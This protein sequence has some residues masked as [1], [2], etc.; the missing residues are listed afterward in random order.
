MITTRNDRFLSGALVFM[1]VLVMQGC[2]TLAPG[3]GHLD[4]VV[5]NGANKPSPSSTDI[6]IVRPGGVANANVGMA[7]RKADTISTSPNTRAL[8]TLLESYEV[9]LDTGTVIIIENPTIFVK[10]GQ[11]F[12]R[13][14]LGKPD[15]MTVHTNH[16]TILDKG[17]SFFVRVDND[18]RAQVIVVDGAVTVSPRN[19]ASWPE[20]VYRA[21]EAATLIGTNEPVSTRVPAS[22]IEAE[23]TWVRRVDAL[24]RVRMPRLDSLTESQARDALSR[25]GMRVLFVLQKTTG[26][27]TPGHVIEQTPTADSWAPAGS[28]ATLVIEGKPRPT[29]EPRDSISRVTTRVCTVPDVMNHTEEEAVKLITDAGYSARR[30]AG[31]AEYV[32]QQS[33]S[34]GTREPCGRVVAYTMAFRIR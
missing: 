20:R 29:T 25:I 32:A 4:G 12:I 16:A 15:S 3:Y 22:A 21:G 30:T 11:L 6:R 8:M 34:P 9:T 18:D 33:L 28:F 1:A 24:T 19:G 27:A 7:I 2:A 13:K 17:T 10:L 23:M 26:T 5:V 14:L 31:R